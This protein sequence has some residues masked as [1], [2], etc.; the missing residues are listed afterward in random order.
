MADI[1]TLADARLALRKVA[2]DTTDD[3]DLT[4]TYIPA[5][6]AVVEDVCGP[7]MTATG[8]TWT[9]DGGKTQI[10]LPT[11]CSAVTQVTETGTVLVA[12]VDYTVNLR[13]GIVT[14][15]STQTP[16][17]FLPGQQNI[18]VTYNVGQYAAPANVPANIKLAARLILRQMFT[19]DQTGARSQFGSPDN[20]VTSTP[21]GF[22]IP[23]RAMELLHA[24]PNVPGFA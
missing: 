4:N 10:L 16:Y 15:G 17:I 3:T 8:L 22:L 2:A 14:R 19:A 9:V 13:S 1:L 23:N 12:S 11:A 6:T 18:V 7:L 5:T 20:S 21:G 24:V